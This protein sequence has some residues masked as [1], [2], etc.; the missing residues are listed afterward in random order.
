MILYVLAAFIIAVIWVVSRS[1]SGFVE[2]TDWTI[3]SPSIEIPPTPE[4]TPEERY[5]RIL[6]RID[7]LPLTEKERR[8]VSEEARRRYIDESVR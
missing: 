5:H 2:R 7:N 4:E 1:V 6:K 8:V 3:K